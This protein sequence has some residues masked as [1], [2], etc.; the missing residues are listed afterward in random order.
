MHVAGNTNYGQNA[1]NGA[2]NAVSV[3]AGGNFCLAV[4]ADGSVRAAGS[5][6]SGQ[7]DVCEW[8]DVRAVACGPGGRR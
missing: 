4:F 1:L 6:G 8:S 3:A 7:C 5:K 2:E